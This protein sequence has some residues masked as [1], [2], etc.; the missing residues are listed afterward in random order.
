MK[1]IFGGVRGSFPV[2]EPDC[3]RYGGATSSFLVASKYGGKILVDMGTGIRVLDKYIRSQDNNP[4]LLLLMTHYHLDHLIGFP[5]FTPLYEEDWRITMAAPMHN[6]Q[7]IDVV[8]PRILEQPYWPLQISGLQADIRFTNLRDDGIKNPLHFESMDVRWCP[9]HHPGGCTAYRFDDTHTG[10]SLVIATDVEWNAS[11]VDER[12]LFKELCRTPSPVDV[13]VF[14]GQYRE[15]IYAQYEGWG[16]SSW[17]HAVEV[18]EFVGVDR[19]YVSHHSPY[20][21]DAAL[22]EVGAALK[23]K[24]SGARMARQG[25]VV[26]V[27]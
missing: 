12:E 3:V 23:K 24:M 20:N 26:N 18:A 4:S 11:T 22:D 2:E 27:G 16:H 17:K 10:A 7:S 25:E 15:H 6:G 14:D 21:N 19:L 1:L 8:V 5:S 9:V 13:L